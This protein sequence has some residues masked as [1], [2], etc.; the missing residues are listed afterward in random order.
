MKRMK[1]PWNKT[2]KKETEEQRWLNCA[3]KAVEKKQR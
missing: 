3:N 2:A 1:T